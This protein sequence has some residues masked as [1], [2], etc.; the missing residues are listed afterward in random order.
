MDNIFQKRIL[1]HLGLA[2]SLILPGIL[3]AQDWAKTNIPNLHRADMRDLGYPLVNEIPPNSSAITSLLTARD[4]LIYG[5]TSGE[6]AYL[7]VY[8]PRIN[9]VRHLGRLKAQQGIHHAIAE[10]RQGYIYIGTGKNVLEEIE[11]SPGGIG[12]D[13]IDTTL[14][15]DIENHYAGYPGGRL[16]RYNPKTD[17]EKVNLPEMDCEAQDLG[18]PLPGD[19]IYALTIN[20]EGTVV[21]GLTY[22][23]GH[24]FLF[25]I[26]IGQFTDLGPIDENIVFHGPERHWRSLPRALICDL[27]GRVFT[28]STGGELKYYDPEIKKICSTG[29]KIP[30]D[31]YYAQFFEDYAV[32]DYFTMHNAGVIYGGTSDGYLFR[33][34]P[35]EMTLHNLGKPRMDRRLRCLTVAGNGKIYIMAGERSSARPC[36]LYSYDPPSGGFEDLGLFIVDRSP[37]YYWRGYQ[38]DAM[39]TG[40]DGTIYLGESERRS[41]LFLLIPNQEGC[42]SL[43][44]VS[45][46]KGPDR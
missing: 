8:D 36:Q 32:V 4:G 15:R 14:W 6:R 30:G 13:R 3:F 23:H 41:H 42:N 17:N 28:S 25:D 24:F 45:S 7:F 35:R 31:Y 27:A 11:I 43:Q 10:D 40:K 19:S 5:G 9:K 46:S 39:T 2:H 37:Y 1:V 12:K 38:F 34:N 33:L 21:Y 16:F 18:V 20:P 22:P 26:S 29:L 44:K